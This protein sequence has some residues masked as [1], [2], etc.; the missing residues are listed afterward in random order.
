MPNVREIK[1]A[2]PENIVLHISRE[3]HKIHNY[4][5]QEIEK[6]LPQLTIMSFG[7]PE[8][9]I[10]WLF[11]RVDIKPEHAELAKKLKEIEKSDLSDDQKTYARLETLFPNLRGNNG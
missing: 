1:P 8:Q 2:T 9:I 7:G 4:W 3:F 11:E 5:R 6:Y 10:K